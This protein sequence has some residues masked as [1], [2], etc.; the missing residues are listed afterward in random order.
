[1]KSYVTRLHVKIFTW[2]ASTA[3]PQF[4]IFLLSTSMT[5]TDLACL[6]LIVYYILLDDLYRFHDYIYHCFY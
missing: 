1:M 5:I 2:Y 3:T 6:I 4:H